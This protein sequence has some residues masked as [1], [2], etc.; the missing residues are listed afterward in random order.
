M[1]YDEKFDWCLELPKVKP[2]IQPFKNII[3]HLIKQIVTHRLEK[4]DYYNMRELK[5]HIFDEKIYS[6][7]NNAYK[8]HIA[9]LA[10]FLKKYPSYPR[11]FNDKSVPIEDILPMYEWEPY[12]LLYPPD[13]DKIYS[14]LVTFNNQILAESNEFIV[15]HYGEIERFIDIFTSQKLIDFLIEEDQDLFISIENKFQSIKTTIGRI[16][17]N[18]QIFK[19]MVFTLLHKSKDSRGITK[20]EV[21]RY[22]QKSL[23][24]DPITSI[25]LFEELHRNGTIY[26]HKSGW[27]QSST[28]IRRDNGLVR[29]FSNIINKIPTDILSEL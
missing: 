25:Q 26:E 8:E 22:A 10:V 15:S 17:D 21:Y 2:K 28:P 24:F 14:L 18:S 29:A 6:Q 16:Q 11:R 19:A 23:G 3:D 9:S 1:Y 27:F 12:L 4:E 5:K 13:V 20:K 7:F